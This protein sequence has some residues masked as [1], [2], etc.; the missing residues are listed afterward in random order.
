[1][2]ELMIRGIPASVIG[3]TSLLA[4]AQMSLMARIFVYWAGGCWYPNP[5][6]ARETVT[7]E[8]IV[9]AIEDAT[10]TSPA[11]AERKMESIENLY[12]TVK[13]AGRTR[14]T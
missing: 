9:Q 10:G 7:R 14:G 12:E 1:V 4:K 3:K 6:H 5:E 13:Q 8:S 11:E 2:K